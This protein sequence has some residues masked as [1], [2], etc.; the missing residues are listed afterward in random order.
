MREPGSREQM[1][2]EQGMVEGVA[3]IAL[4]AQEVR[5]DFPILARE[6][7][8]H[9]LAYLDNAATTQKP[10]AMIEAI[11]RYYHR[12]NANVHRGV[13]TLSQEATDLYEDARRT[14]ARFLNAPSEENIV[15]V[16]GCTEAIN[17]VAGT[18]GRSQ[19]RESDE[20]VLSAMEH[21]SN[22]VPW[23]LLCEET[24]AKL[25]VIPMNEEGE[26]LIPEYQQLLND[27]TRLVSVVH[28]SN[29]LG[30]INPIEE[31]IEHAHA[32]GVPV[33]VDGA[34][35]TAHG[36]VDVQALDADFYTLSGH[37]VFG[38]TGIGALYAR[39][40]HLDAM[41]PYHGGGEMIRSVTFEKTTY[42]DPPARFEAGTPN[43]AGAIGLAA[44]LDYVEK[45]GRERIREWE[46][47]LLAYGT[48]RLSQV[49]GLRLIGTAR[50]KTS[51]LSFTLDFAHPHD[52]G[53]I[54]DGEGVAVRTGH[55]CTQPVMAFYGIPATTRASLSFYNT[56]EEIDRLVEAIGK[57]KEIFG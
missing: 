47:E 41:P 34:Q 27:R 44:A 20:I 29:S 7:N 53:T 51:I 57:V 38:P 17:L 37:K 40:E 39:S 9:Q 45:T 22:I 14:V 46:A 21:H 50:R 55:H 10:L 31:I 54:L 26:L 52:V 13:H 28:V 8:G 6:V 35:A 12:F 1:N 11:D 24:G 56:K 18:F 3:D 25:R 19:I 49:D 32:R 43:I 48:E 42:A 2:G 5:S 23:Q 33:L 30:T 36:T 16:R 4:L 15:F